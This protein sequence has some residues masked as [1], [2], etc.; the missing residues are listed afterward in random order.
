MISCF[1]IYF[2]GHSCWFRDR[3]RYRY[4]QIL[5]LQTVPKSA[6]LSLSAAATP[7]LDPFMIAPFAV[8][9]GGF[10]GI[11]DLLIQ[12]TRP[13]IQLNIYFSLLLLLLLQ[14]HFIA[15]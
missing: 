10:G 3:Y 5:R 6:T 7:P 11:G 2:C 15:I 4:S 13:R 14:R 8:G 12:P 1:L 9:R